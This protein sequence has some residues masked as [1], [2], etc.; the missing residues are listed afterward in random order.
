M[1]SC[2]WCATGLGL[3]SGHLEDFVNEAVVFGFLGGHEA[4]PAEITGDFF[5]GAAGVV[6]QQAIADAL[7][8]QQLL[9]HALDVR[10]VALGATTGGVEVDGGMGQ[11]I[12]LAFGATSQQNRRHAPCPSDTY[13]VDVGADDMHGVI[14]G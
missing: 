6:R 7:D 10:G 14:N 11:G 9:D 4:I 1:T 13:R 5:G 3:T 2:A 8:A 12:P